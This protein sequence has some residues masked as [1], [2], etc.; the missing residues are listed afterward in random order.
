[1]APAWPGGSCTQL[2]AGLNTCSVMPPEASLFILLSG[3][4]KVTFT[5]RG[6]HANIVSMTADLLLPTY[7]QVT[8]QTQPH[9]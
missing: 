4:L 8:F 1:M 9:M 7:I 5:L 3:H 2:E 6:R